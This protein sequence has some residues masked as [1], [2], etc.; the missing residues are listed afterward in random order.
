MIYNPLKWIQPIRKRCPILTKLLGNNPNFVSS[1]YRPEYIKHSEQRQNY[2]INRF[3]DVQN[4]YFTRGNF[5]YITVMALVCTAVGFWFYSY[6]YFL[7][8]C[9]IISS[10]HC[11]YAILIVND[12]KKIKPVLLIFLG[13]IFYA[14]NNSPQFQHM[15]PVKC[16]SE[17]YQPNLISIFCKVYLI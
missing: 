3:I 10:D 5:K 1:S 12:A 4:M 6:I 17:I 15:G 8:A 2:M 14:L 16:L 9:V 11:G 13:V 7:F